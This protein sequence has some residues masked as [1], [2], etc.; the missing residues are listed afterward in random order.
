MTTSTSIYDEPKTRIT[1]LDTG[2]T[3]YELDATHL[4]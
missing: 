4:G 1:D 2:A 3:I